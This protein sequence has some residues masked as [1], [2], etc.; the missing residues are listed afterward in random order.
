M[1]LNR[2]L[3]DFFGKHT[4][5]QYDIP[6]RAPQTVLPKNSKKDDIDMDLV[7]R[8]L[9]FWDSITIFCQLL[10]MGIVGLVVGG[11]ILSVIIIIL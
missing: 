7:V 9:G 2:K 10:V 8:H 1:K 6:R 11:F 3:D 4:S 5:R